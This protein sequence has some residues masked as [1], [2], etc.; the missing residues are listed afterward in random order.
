MNND[1]IKIN[2]NGIDKD[3]RVLFIIDKGFYY[4]IYTDLNNQQ[5]N[6]NLYVAKVTNISKISNTLPISDDEWKM[7]ESEYMKVIKEH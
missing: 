2:S 1:I 7:I 5:F 4:I 6:K 3:Y